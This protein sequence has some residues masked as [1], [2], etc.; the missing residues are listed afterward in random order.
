[1]HFSSLRR[2]SSSPVAVADTSTYFKLFNLRST[3][4]PIS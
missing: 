4:S 1:V 2:Q 3:L